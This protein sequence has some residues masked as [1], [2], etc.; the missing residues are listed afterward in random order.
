MSKLNQPF[1]ASVFIAH[2]L[3][4][5]GLSAHAQVQSSAVPTNQTPS[6]HLFV[7]SLSKGVTQSSQASP[8]RGDESTLKNKHS[9]PLAPEV[10]FALSAK[11]KANSLDINFLIAPDYYLYKDKISIRSSEANSI[12]VFNFPL[13]LIKYDDTFAKN[14]EAYRQ[15]LNLTGIPTLASLTKELVIDVRSQGC[16][17]IG[18]CYPPQLQRLTFAPNE[19]SAIVQTLEFVAEKTA[20]LQ[21]VN[22]IT[23]PNADVMPAASSKLDSESRVSKVLK[24]SNPFLLVLGF[25]GFGLLLSFT[26]CVLPMVPIVSAIVLG[27]H[28]GDQHAISTAQGLKFSLAY[29]F[30][31]CVTYTLIGVAAGLAGAG[32]SAFLQHPVLLMSFGL[33]MIGLA[34]AQLGWYTLSLPQAWLPKLAAVQSKVGAQRYLGIVLM[35]ALSA[36]MVGPC[37]TAP[38]AGVLAYIA[39]TGDAWLGAVALFSLAFGMGIPLLL[40]GAGGAHFL[41]KTGSWMN[42]VTYGF[43]IMLVCVAIWT[44]QSLLPAWLLTMSWL[45]VLLMTAEWMGAFHFTQ[46]SNPAKRIAQA[47]GWMLVV[48]ASAVVWGMAA[49]RFDVVQPLASISRSSQM[50]GQ[51]PDKVTFKTIAAQ[52][53]TLT[54][55]KLD[56]KPALLDVYADWCVSC[57]EL[58]RFTFKDSQVS[59]L[60]SQFN[61]IKV[62]ATRNTVSDQALLKSLKLFGPPAIVFYN[63]Q[64]I[65]IEGARVIGFQAAQPFS[66]HLKQVLALNREKK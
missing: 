62:D 24:S 47:I 57:I 49:G 22:A 52:D 39:Q 25:V 32:L 54:L 66:E 38:L 4:S 5:I 56:G 50:S 15:Q 9:D 58:E 20:D 44:V 11:R 17:D 53:L 31:M 13:G 19:T 2:L 55:F 27:K 21:P 64:G 43:G 45:L 34:G 33:L 16:A 7:T 35:G 48:W 42:R 46:A 61:L 6:S 8:F 36:V 26:P 18:I 37:V 14:V 63:T 1:F 10:A 65:E 12:G 29:V 60:M 41:P 51:S 28:S 23:I 3:F 30:G 59:E 40:I